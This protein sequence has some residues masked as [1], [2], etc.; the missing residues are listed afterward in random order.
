MSLITMLKRAAW[1]FWVAAICSILLDSSL[2]GGQHFAQLNEG[3]HDEN[4][5]LH[6]RLLLSTEESMATPSSVKA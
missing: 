5:H 4:V 6:A 3:T 1:S 2:V